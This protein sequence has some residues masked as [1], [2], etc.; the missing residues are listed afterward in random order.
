M[1]TS[2][3]TVLAFILS[4]IF[5]ASAEHPATHT[6]RPNDL[7]RT[8]RDIQ[9]AYGSVRSA[10]VKIEKPE[11][12]ALSNGVIVTAEGHILTAAGTAR[13]QR[14]SPIEVELADGRRMKAVPLGW[15]EQWGI[16]LLK[17]A[18]DA[19]LPHVP[20]DDTPKGPEAGQECVAVGFH[21]LAEPQAAP[22]GP[23][24]R[25]GRAAIVCERMWCSFTGPLFADYGT[26]LFS[27]QGKLL[28]TYTA[29]RGSANPGGANRVFTL[30]APVRDR[31]NELVSGKNIDVDEVILFGSDASEGPAPAPSTSGPD[32]LARASAAT[33]RILPKIRAQRDIRNWSGVIVSENGYV[34]TCAHHER[35][36][37]AEVT[38][39][40]ADGRE[41]PGRVLGMNWVTDVG[42]VK[43]TS[44]GPWPFA[45]VGDSRL[46]VGTP[47]T[48]IGFPHSYNEKKPLIRPTQ[49]VAPPAYGDDLFLHLFTDPETS[50]TVG[51]DSGG[52]LFDATGKLIGLHIQVSPRNSHVRIEALR[53]QWDGL[54]SAKTTVEQKAPGEDGLETAFATAANARVQG[55]TVEVM[56]SGRAPA[57]GP[58]DMARR[59]ADA[60]ACIGLVVSGNGHIVTKYSELDGELSCRLA[61]GV[62]LPARVVRYSREDDLALLKVDATD[63]PK[64]GWST[65]ALAPRTFIAAVIP[66]KAPVVG[67]ISQSSREI[68]AEPQTE[69]AQWQVRDG[70]AGLTFFGEPRDWERPFEKGDLIV[71]VEGRATPDLKAFRE[72]MRP[73]PTT[74]FAYP[75]DKVQ[76]TVVRNTETLHLRCVIPSPSRFSS[77]RESRRQSGF[78]QVMDGDITLSPAQAGA[79]AIDGNGDV[80]GIVIATRGVGHTHILQ[81][82]VVRQFLQGL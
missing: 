32:D 23:V 19:P 59:P 76:V 7:A 20:L 14:G 33:V 34:A 45:E 69:S 79:P 21:F 38:V 43:I 26:G 57:P 4:V 81:A 82:S 3:H 66:G 74:W 13:D 25:F 63:L 9:A 54:I 71:S 56:C 11:Y 17:I 27:M 64:V 37:G 48:A 29:F 55:A 15:S 28:G 70:E 50:Q 6:R 53:K 24:A 5:S 61:S 36:A 62:G 35:L 52:G 77:Q 40:L 1:K 72:V 22:R 49:V 60:A 67:L 47:A 12:R 51:G 8:E 65:T 73:T 31:W 2:A 42:I 80:V 75:G 16:G 58:L 30:V 68:P 46:K 78:A 10:V 44:D 39:A 41:V 18:S